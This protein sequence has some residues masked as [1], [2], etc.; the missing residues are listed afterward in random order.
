MLG[1]AAFRQFAAE[2][3]TLWL[4][5]VSNTHSPAALAAIPR[6]I[7]INSAVEVDLFGQVNAERANGSFNAGAGGLP[8]FAAGA[9]ASAGGRLLICLP[10]TA[11]GGSVSRIV[12]AL[13]DQAVCTLPRHAADAIVTEYGVAELRGLSLDERARAL[14]DIAAPDHR[15]GLAAAWDTMRRRA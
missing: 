5:D 2:L 13:G 1:G 9:Q 14:I 12:P 15:D 10:A 4:T 8:A 11:R 7:A 3:P 6:F